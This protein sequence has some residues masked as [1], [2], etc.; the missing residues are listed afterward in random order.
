MTSSNRAWSTISSSATPEQSGSPRSSG[1]ETPHRKWPGAP[2]GRNHTPDGSTTS[3]VVAC[4]GSAPAAAPSQWT[5]KT[6]RLRAATGSGATCSLLPQR[7]TT[8]AA[9]A[10]AALTTVSAPS[11]C[12]CPPA[13]RTR[14]ARTRM[15]PCSGATSRPSTLALT[16]RTPRCAALARSAERSAHGSNQPSECS[17]TQPR[18]TP[19][20]FS[21]GKRRRRAS[22]ESRRVQLTP[23]ASWV[24]WFRRSVASPCADARN[25]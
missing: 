9:K 24:A 7:R 25:R 20:T 19:S 12:S 2:S 3:P 13:P 10:P 22:G 4:G 15:P 1:G 8:S 11:A 5:P 16:K 17:P 21:Q 6:Q 23:C 18:A 14:A